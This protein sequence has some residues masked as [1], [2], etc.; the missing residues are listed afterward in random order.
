M[1]PIAFNRNMSPVSYNHCLYI[2][3]TQAETLVLPVAHVLPASVVFPENL[4]L[5]FRWDTESI[6]GNSYLNFLFFFPA[7]DKNMGFCTGIFY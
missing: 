2:K 7:I 6:V 4:F 3:K 1:L 5:L